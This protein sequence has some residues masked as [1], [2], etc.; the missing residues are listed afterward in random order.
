MALEKGRVVAFALAKL[1]RRTPLPDRGALGVVLVHP[2]H[3]RKGLGR[4]LVAVV[5]ERLRACG[6]GFMGAASPAAFRFWP[7][8]PMDLEDAVPFFQSVGYVGKEGTYDLVRTLDDF[9][10]ANYGAG[11][12]LH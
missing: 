7:G 8:V 6:V 4:A 2:D 5:A 12:P 10:T 1:D 11:Q 9:E 3:R